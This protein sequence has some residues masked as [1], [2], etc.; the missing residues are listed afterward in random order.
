[1]TVFRSS[2]DIA[3]LGE[4]RRHLLQTL[5]LAPPVP[6]E[7]RDLAEEDRDSRTPIYVDGSTGTSVT[8]ADY[9][10]DL[11]LLAAALQTLGLPRDAVVGV[12]LHNSLQVPFAFHA[13]VLAGYAV[14]PVSPSLTRDE[15]AAQL[16]KCR[17]AAVVTDADLWDVSSPAASP[18]NPKPLLILASRPP[19]GSP[20]P[21]G[22]P[23][24]PDLLELGRTLPPVRF[25]PLSPAD[26]ERT[27]CLVPFSS[28][29]SGAPKAVALTHANQTAAALQ[30]GSTMRGALAWDPVGGTKAAVAFVPMAHVYGCNY[31][32]GSLLG[33]RVTV[34]MMAKFAPEPYLRLVS[35]YRPPVLFLVPPVVVRLIAMP[36]EELAPYDLSSV[37]YVFCGAAPMRAETE[38]ALV[39]VFP[40]EVQVKQ[41]YGMTEMSSVLRC[42][43]D[44]PNPA[45]SVG[46][47]SPSSEMIVVSPDGRLLGPGEEGEL[48]ARGP[49]R[50]V[51]YLGDPAASLAAIAFRDGERDTRGPDGLEFTGA[52]WLRT[53]DVGYIDAEGRGYIT[54]RLKE[55]IKVNAMQVAPSELEG[56]LLLHPRVADCAVIG[57]PDDRFGEVPRA[58]VVP[59]PASGGEKFDPVE[60]VEWA[61]G[62]TAAHKRLRGGVVAVDEIPRN[63]NGKVLRRVLRERE[64]AS[65]ARL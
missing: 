23:T 49:N 6:G 7:P 37:R 64:A 31:F 55:L 65:K 21:P 43:L 11:W 12:H 45:G 24:L 2:I 13:A 61:A 17:A 54:D 14:S 30:I 25:N 19:P 50:S 18:L 5:R 16:A 62:R 33:L 10:R 53:G 59:A 3:S 8:Y 9:K 22:T 1:M 48:W 56:L 58:F 27:V 28:G 36:R 26:A 35:R 38:Q 4:H 32:M 42:T 29:T 41:G 57:V 46:T 44:A 60:V 51:G 47:L 40:G 63:S 20:V 34:V 15:V 52:G 39:G